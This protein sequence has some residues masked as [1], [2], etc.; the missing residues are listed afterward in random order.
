MSRFDQRLRFA[1]AAWLIG[2]MAPYLNWPNWVVRLSIFDAFGHPYVD[3]PGS[4][5]FLIIAIMIVPGTIATLEIA[6]RSAKVL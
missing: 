4:R 5:S 3:F 1:G 2:F 6:E